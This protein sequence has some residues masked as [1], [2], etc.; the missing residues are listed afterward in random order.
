[1]KQALRIG[2][3]VPAAL[4]LA[5]ALAQAHGTV[6]GIGHFYNGAFHPFLVVPHLMALLALGLLAGQNGLARIGAVAGSLATGLAAGLALSGLPGLPDTDAA[7]LA[8]AGLVGI[9]VAIARPL[10]QALVLPLVA[11]IALAIGLGSGA[12]GV[13]GAKRLAALAGTACGALL[14]MLWTAAVASFARAW[15]AQIA[16]RVIGSW[17]AA[18]VLLV[19]ALN[20]FGPRRDAAVAPPAKASAPA[21]EATR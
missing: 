1:M 11:A 14:V 12:E 7:V 10:S 19:L 3:V 8:S 21:S 2:P 15:W 13:E 18:S 20:W 6:P 4:L 9:A 5:P 16:L 17:L